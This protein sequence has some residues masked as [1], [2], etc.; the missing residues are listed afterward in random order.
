MFCYAWIISL[1]S[2]VFSLTKSRI[3]RFHRFFVTGST[4]IW[5]LPACGDTGDDG[6]R[7]LGTLLAMFLLHFF[8]SIEYKGSSSWRPIRRWCRRALSFRQLAM[9]PMLFWHNIYTKFSVIA[10]SL[11]CIW[12]ICILVLSCLDN[13]YIIYDS[14]VHTIYHMYFAVS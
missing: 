11:K 6:V 7:I 8:V 10:T 3:R 12:C 5:H 1:F 14:V 2:H 9:P 4:A 13:L